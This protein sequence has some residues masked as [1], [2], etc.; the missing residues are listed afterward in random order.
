MTFVKGNILLFV[1]KARFHSTV[2]EK[3]R[4]KLIYFYARSKLLISEFCEPLTYS[5]M[6]DPFKIMSVRYSQ[7]SI[8]TQLRHLQ[9]SDC[10]EIREVYLARG[11]T[12]M[13]QFFYFFIFFLHIKITIKCFKTPTN[14]RFCL[15]NK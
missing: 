11:L 10:S 12:A 4:S 3:Q 2:L 6:L 5:I 15:N 9:G 8:N 14:Y 1:L 7:Y 13:R